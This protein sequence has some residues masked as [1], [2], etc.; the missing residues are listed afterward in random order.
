[1]H[2]LS[3]LFLVCLV[4]PFAWAAT[5]A[6]TVVSTGGDPVANARVR[7]YRLE[8]FHAFRAR[9]LEGRERAVL[10]SATSDEAGAFT[11]D[12]KVSGVVRLVVEREGFAP[13]IVNG[14]AD[15]QFV[16]ELKPAAA[17]TGR[18]TADGKPV[19][20]ATIVA[21]S[22]NGEWTTRTDDRGA[23]TIAEPKP[24]ATAVTVI[25]PDYA[26]LALPVSPR[27]SLDAALVPGSTISGKVVR[28]NGAAVANARVVASGWSIATSGEDGTFVLRHVAA[29]ARVLEA[30][31]GSSY[32]T[33]PRGEGSVTIQ[34]AERPSIAGTVRDADKRPLAGAA[35]TAWREDAIRA[36]ENTTAIADEKGS[37]SIPYCAEGDYYVYT[38]A[39]GEL[40]F[41]VEHVA[42]SGAVSRVE[43]V[44]KKKRA[45]SGIVVDEQKRPVAGAVVQLGMMQMPLVYAFG[46]GEQ[47]PTA[48]TA[49]N[50]R[51]RLMIGE[52]PDGYPVRLQ[53]S[54]RGY[55]AGATG[56]LNLK[57][58]ANVTI[59]L[60]AGI[61]L[62]G[63]V[64][65]EGGTPVAGAGVIA[66]EEPFGAAP[67]P[68]DAALASGA[69]LPFVESG[70][71]GKFVV[72]LNDKPHD[73]GVWKTGYS[74][75][76]VAGVA[77]KGGEP[78]KI[79]LTAGVAIRGR[80][81]R[82]GAPAEAGTITAEING[83][84]AGQAAVSADGTFVLDGL[85]AGVYT[86]QYVDAA[87]RKGETRVK[88]PA[89]DVVL[90]LAATG[91][92]RGR[93]VDAATGQT[94]TR[95]SVVSGTYETAVVDGE[96]S[97]TM[98]VQPGAVE[99]TVD[100]EG[101]VD[102]KET[103]TVAA[104]QPSEVTVRL[105]RGRSI[106]GRIIGDAQSPVD[107]ARVS[108]ADYSA[109][110]MSGDDGEFRLEGVSREA[111][112]L[113]VD[114]D[115]YLSRTATV[116]AGEADVRLDIVLSRGRTVKGRVVTSDG[117]PVE[118]ATVRA[119]GDAH[120]TATTTATGAFTIQGL[121]EGA[122]TFAAAHGELRSEPVAESAATVDGELVLRMKPS[123]GHGSLHGS[124][125][126]FV[127]GG[128]QYGTVQTNQATRFAMIARDGTFRLEKIAA[129]DVEVR[130]TANATDGR[131]ISTPPVKVTLAPNADV[132]V[133]LAF[134]KDIVVR[135]TVVEANV[136]A[137]G[138]R[139]TFSGGGVDA[140]AMTDERGAYEIAGLVPDVMYD[141][142]VNGSGRDF[143]T[144]YLVKSSSTFDIRVEWWRVEGRVIGADRAPIAGAAIELTAADKRDAGDAKSDA[145][146]AFALETVPGRYV[147]T[148][149]KEGFATV[150][151][152]VDAGGPPS[153]VTMTPTKGLRVRIVDARSGATVDGYAA[154]IDASGQQRA[155]ASEQ[156][157]DGTFLLSLAPGAYRVAV[158]ANEFASQSARASVP[159]EGELRI[160]LTPG[161]TLIVH[162]DRAANDV[163]KLILPNGE[164]YVRC[165]CNGI[166]E[167]RLEGLTTKIEHIAPGSYTMQVLDPRG[168]V[169]TS[170]PVTIVEGQVTTAE[171]RVPQ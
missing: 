28:K 66:I 3:S 12:T 48:R 149:S 102:G 131:S 135:G 120:E 16:V 27:M 144:R 122:Y 85:R 152:P 165:Q 11:L 6:G 39:L 127:E 30:F 151:Q 129:G 43:L 167:I 84:P 105:T 145:G 47:F 128:W 146:G 104:N 164:E 171:I 107:G 44:A 17:R 73:I 25:H 138:R 124:V 56:A 1:M 9:V 83:I 21:T 91:T 106:T 113:E 15:D 5:L 90:E 29:D 58:R 95:Y 55:A 159:F 80:V 2:R 136:P 23:Y 77:P 82:K 14:L 147:L 114:A 62:H 150:T 116:D 38:P 111:M 10:A 37:F 134:S 118:G 33:A 51:F 168:F 53:A 68:I 158:S 57:E 169:K 59:T 126:G 160:A 69:L 156:K 76:L 86:L 8:T 18:V 65:N 74:G 133:K 141:V 97:F 119:M 101:Y 31:D 67:L 157:K 123:T 13:A 42:V 72:R 22:A 19:S 46:T 161:G 103:V 96:D 75:A 130:A 148:V 49:A 155:K 142:T 153:I 54:R 88:A 112:T 64:T 98:T 125:A 99:L 117:A 137:I 163:V 139:I 61:E 89:N 87:D 79:V 50:G 81:D 26:A 162:A 4:A 45:L 60:P 166:A 132:E 36:N 71:D 70:D 35:V 41:D 92:I 34:V 140:S 115:G 24:W 110:D 94:L 143:E 109:V 52:I 121:G 40:E 32:G 154:A 93:V 170:Y 100:A 108:L 7:A 20:G 63:I 78:R